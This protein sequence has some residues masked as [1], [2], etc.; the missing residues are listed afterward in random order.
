MIEFEDVAPPSTK[1]TCC[2]TLLVYEGSR[3][4][5]SRRLETPARESAKWRPGIKGVSIGPLDRLGGSRERPREKGDGGKWRTREKE[6]GARTPGATVSSLGYRRERKPPATASPHL[7]CAF[8]TGS[9]RHRAPSYAC[10]P[11]ETVLFPLGN[12]GM[13]NGLSCNTNSPVAERHHRTNTPSLPKP[14]HTVVGQAG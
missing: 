9:P 8:V 10:A 11:G 7:P 13:W 6:K 14:F 2:S 4:W 1:P 3:L 5:L 12:E